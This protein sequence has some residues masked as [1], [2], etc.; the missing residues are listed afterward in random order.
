[1]TEEARKTPPVQMT[2]APPPPPVVTPDRVTET[3]AVEMAHALSRE[4]DQAANEEPTAL[5]TTEAHE[6]AMKP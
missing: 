1:V 5:T 3:N 2:G 4:L 6:S